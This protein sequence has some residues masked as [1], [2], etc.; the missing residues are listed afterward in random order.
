[1]SAVYWHPVLTA[2]ALKTKPVRVVLEGVPLVLFR[3]SE[4]VACLKDICPHRFAPLSMGR[5][6]ENSIECPYHGWRFD[7]GG[8]C[9]KIPLHE[10][11]TPR[12]YGSCYA[13]Q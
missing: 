4:G 3:T 8:R 5:I 2:K 7:G 12:R 6:V 9:T 11:E 10:G 1:M 13:A